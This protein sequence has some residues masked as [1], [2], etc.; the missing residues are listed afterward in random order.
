MVQ[1]PVATA[2]C[3]APFAGAYFGAALGYGQQRTEIT[4]ETV[5]AFSEGVKFKDTD[6]G[7]AIG[8][9]AG[10]NWQH[11][12]HPFVF[13][14]ETDFNWLNTKPTA[15][16][17]EAGPGGTETVSLQGRMDWFGTLRVRAGY[18]VHDNW[19]LYATGGLAYAQVDHKFND[20][21]VNASSVAPGFGPFSQSN[22]DTK[23]GWTVGGGAEFLH[24][25][26]W[27]LRAEALFVDLGSETHSY[28]PPAL[29]A[30]QAECTATAKWDDQF[31]VAR[32]G[33]AYKFDDTRAVVPLK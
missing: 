5:G 8:G 11:C 18:V 33:L 3:E 10:Y 6:G 21:N 26:H 30:A 15:F 16:D 27:L 9:Y 7:F 1:R 24:D 25:T 31:W 32:L 13:G 4:N 17:I 19:L 23:A 2:C 28:S 20:D 29:C 14:V 22:K 12:C